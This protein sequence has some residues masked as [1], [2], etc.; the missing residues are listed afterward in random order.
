[1]PNRKTDTNN[2]TGFSTDAI[3][4]SD[5]WPEASYEQRATLYLEHLHYQQGLCWTMVHHPRVPQKLRRQ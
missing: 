1:M 2:N 5:R 3:G 4:L